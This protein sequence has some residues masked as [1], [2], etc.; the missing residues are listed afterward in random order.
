MNRLLIEILK[1]PCILINSLIRTPSVQFNISTKFATTQK[2]PS[3]FE[4]KEENFGVGSRFE[5]L[6]SV[7]SSGKIRFGKNR[8]NNDPD[9]DIFGTLS[10][11]DQLDM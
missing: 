7:R 6:D 9:A 2:E 4:E 10:N 3:R 8:P 5:Q 11:N 1:R